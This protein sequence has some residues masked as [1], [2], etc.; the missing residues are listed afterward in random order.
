MRAI[1]LLIALLIA[2]A[3]GTGAL[4]PGSSAPVPFV[5]PRGQNALLHGRGLYQFDPAVLASEGIIWDRVNLFLGVP[6]L[7]FAIVLANKGSMRGRIL[8]SGMLFYFF[9]VY[10]MYANMV[11]LNDM[12]LV[13]IA[14]FS[15]SGIALIVELLGLEIDLLVSRVKPSFP[16]RLFIAFGFASGLA[17]L[18][19]W[20]RLIVPIIR[21]GRF[22]EELAGMTTL[23]TQAL[24]IGIVV[25]LS[26]SAAILL[27]RRSNLGFLMAGINVTFGLLMFITIPAWIAIPLIQNGQIKLIEAIPFLVLC[28]F[29]IVLT[30]IFFRNVSDQPITSEA[31]A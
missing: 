4:A 20:L 31:R 25:P 27:W 10:L 26:L 17:I 16:R 15:L 28:M 1:Q 13:Y 24:D 2:V 14:I 7:I 18:L 3:A 29:G 9:Y 8:L 21:T 12:F 22:P 5:T 19:L 6:L 30:V 23:Q 11:A